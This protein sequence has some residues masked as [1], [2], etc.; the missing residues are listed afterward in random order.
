MIVTNTTRL[1][2]L[3]NIFQF[4]WTFEKYCI[5]IKKK[6]NQNRVI[7]SVFNQN[8]L[9]IY[10]LIYSVSITS[11]SIL[12]DCNKYNKVE[13][14]EKYISIWVNIWKVLHPN[15]KTEKSG[16][17]NFWG[18]QSKLAIFLP[19]NIPSLHNF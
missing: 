2:T 17:Y 18:V 15:Q 6:K 4:E 5:L 16:S 7:M 10:L 11:K 8:E 12:N 9:Y 13:N 19:L 1:K 14:I 3:K